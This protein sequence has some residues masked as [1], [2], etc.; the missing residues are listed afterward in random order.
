MPKKNSHGPA[1]MPELVVTTTTR[2]L[3]AK[4]KRCTPV[5]VVAPWG[6]DKYEYGDG[7]WEGKDGQLMVVE[8]LGSDHP[9]CVNCLPAQAFQWLAQHDHH[10]DIGGEEKA[11]TR[12]LC[13]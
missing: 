4:L 9:Q 7:I 10:I 3:A 13:Q 5:F 11:R 8:G 2:A 1:E 12:F 6:G